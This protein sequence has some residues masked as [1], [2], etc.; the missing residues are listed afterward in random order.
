MSFLKKIQF[1]TLLCLFLGGVFAADPSYNFSPTSGSQLKLHCNY[2]WNLSLVANSQNYN[3]FESTIRYDSWNISLSHWSVNSPFGQNQWYVLANGLYRT[4]WALPAWQKS[5]LNVLAINFWFRTFRNILSTTFFFTDR[6]GNPVI[7]WSSTTDDGSTLNGYDVNSADILAWVYPATY[8]FVPLPCIPD[9]I[10][11]TITNIYPSNGSRYIR[12]NQVVSF[13]VYD[14]A[15]E[16]TINWPLPLG[17]NNRRHY[18]YQWFSTGI[19]SNYV[20]SP[21]SVDNQ[22]WVNKESINAVVSCL[23]CSSA[24][25]YFL[26]GSSLNISDWYWDASHNQWTWNSKRRWYTVSFNAPA[27]YEVEKEISISLQTIDNPNEYWQIHTWQISIS[28]N[29]PQ[30]PVVTRLSPEASSFVSP[31]K[32]NPI[33]LFVSDDWAGIDTWSLKITISSSWGLMTGYTYS[34]SELHI[35]LSW[36]NYGLGNAWKY[37]VEFYPYLD[38]PANETII[39]TWEVS[40]LSNNYTTFTTSF[41]TRPDCSYFGC[42][43]ILNVSV[44]SWNFAGLYQFTW[45]TLIVTWVLNNSLYPYLTWNDNDILFCW[46]EWTGAKLISNWDIVDLNDVIINWIVYSANDLYIT[47]ANFSMHNWVI[48]VN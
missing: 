33:R 45:N 10:N 26:S 47:G 17:L 44:L 38:L 12:S 16:A 11:P 32:T 48:T 43:T 13:L 41:V 6:L 25:S 20:A 18:W 24:W 19:L 27:P 28:F 7:F 22:E 36:W 31:S 1:L 21:A 23:T 35:V 40:D 34:W 15:G 39:I 46:Y 2:I 30:N 8:T 5:S 14:W 29:S 37:I 4:Y 42:N 3:A 9:T